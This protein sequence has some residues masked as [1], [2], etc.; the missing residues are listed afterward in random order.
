LRFAIKLAD[1]ECVSKGITSFQDAGSALETIDIFHDM[2]VKGELRTR[3]YVMISEPNAR[4]ARRL[5]EYRM[6]GVG[7]NHLTVRSIKC[8]IDGA[9]GSRGAWLLEP[10]SDDPSS[11]GLAT[12]DVDY[13]KETARLAAQHDFQLCIHAIGDRA[14]REVLDLYEGAFGT[15]EHLARRRWRIEHAQHLHPDDIPR[16]GELGVIASMQ[17]IHCT[18]DAPWV[19][20][21]LGE[22]RS[23]E[24]AYVW[25][26]LIDSGALVSNGTDAPVEDVDPIASYYASVTRRPAQGEAFNPEQAMSRIEALKS[27]TIN[28][29][30]AAFEENLK[31]TL[32][33]R[34]LAD[35]VVLSQDITSVPAGE[36]LATEI[37]FTIIGGEIAYQRGGDAGGMPRDRHTAGLEAG[38]GCGGM[39]MPPLLRRS[40]PG[41]EPT[42]S[43]VEMSDM[44]GA[45]EK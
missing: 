8:S 42:L 10:Y 24:G 26:S 12:L 37:L 29:A 14:N 30:T 44:Q 32:T 18:S 34:K 7:D 13:L 35:L 25:R 21:R 33:P 6:I 9:L 45:L 40:G 36:I 15:R 17:G 27:Y 20:P 5:P 19:V 23:R 31:G 11:R 41:G 2:A 1:E 22:E 3:L 16:F 4:L 28:A 38:R 39:D 43:W